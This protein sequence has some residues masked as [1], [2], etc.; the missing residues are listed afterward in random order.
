M[1][2]STVSYYTES[3]SGAHVAGESG[4]D[5]EGLVGALRVA[6]SE[7]FLSVC[8]VSVRGVA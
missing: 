5:A 3:R 1:A 2:K 4:T 7:R 8:G 6:W